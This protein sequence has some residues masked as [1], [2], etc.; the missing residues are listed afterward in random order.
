MTAPLIIIVSGPPASGKTTLGKKIADEFRL[1]FINKDG[2]KELLFDNLGWSD[3]EW[4]KRL[5]VASYAILYFI[6]EAQVRAAKPFVIESNFHPAFDSEKFAEMQRRYDFRTL[7]VQCI[8]D[9]DVLYER[10]KERA[11]SGD[12]HPGH[13]DEMNADEFEEILRRGRHDPLDIGG[14]II[15]VDLTDYDA[16]D[17]PAL[18]ATIRD[19]LQR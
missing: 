11:N 1:P 5:G 10:F 17:Y 2:I 8:A 19:H 16:V 9:G 6:L 14:E 12:R 7:Q 18:F 13:G 15:E 3:R 4:S